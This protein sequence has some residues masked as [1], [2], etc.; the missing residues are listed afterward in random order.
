M[1]KHFSTYCIQIDH[2][3]FQ[4]RKQLASRMDLSSTTSF[5]IKLNLAGEGII[6]GLY[7]ENTNIIFIT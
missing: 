6:P 3:S 7:P 4:F 2:L 1:R 5:I